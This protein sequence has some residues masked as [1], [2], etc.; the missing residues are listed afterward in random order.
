MKFHIEC[1]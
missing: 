1:R